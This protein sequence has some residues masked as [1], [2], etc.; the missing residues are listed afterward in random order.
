MLFFLAED[1]GHI[2]LVGAARAHVGEMLAVDRRAIRKLALRFDPF[3]VDEMIGR[4]IYSRNFRSEPRTN[5]RPLVVSQFADLV[6]FELTGVLRNSAG[7]KAPYT[8]H[9]TICGSETPS[10]GM[11]RLP[12]ASASMVP[13]HIAELPGFVRRPKSGR[14]QG[15]YVLY[16]P[17]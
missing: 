17:Q 9:S 10:P 8:G 13:A 16:E 4:D 7:S 1:H 2:D 14:C 6:L 5:S 15:G 3:A 11:N 12:L